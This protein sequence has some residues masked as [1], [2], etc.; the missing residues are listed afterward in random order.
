MKRHGW[1]RK[2][3]VKILGGKWQDYV[4][5]EALLG[6]GGFDVIYTDTFAEDYAGADISVFRPHVE[7]IEDP[8]DTALH[9]FFGHVPTLLAGPLSRFSFFNGLGATSPFLCAILVHLMTP[10]NF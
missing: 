2:R 9:Q 10:S 7:F 4:G 6:F 5:T 1:H 8:R 3:G